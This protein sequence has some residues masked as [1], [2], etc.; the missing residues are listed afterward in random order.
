MGIWC[1]IL[2]RHTVDGVL[3]LPADLIEF[4][5]TVHIKDRPD[6]TSLGNLR[7]VKG[8]LFIRDCVNLSSLGDLRIIDG[9]LDCLNCPELSDLGELSQVR[10]FINVGDTAVR[11]IPDHLEILP[12]MPGIPTAKISSYMHARS[13]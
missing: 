6:I 4:P 3:I 12:L 9:P 1:E 10:G 11:S 7:R 13:E 5:E 8:G 2:R